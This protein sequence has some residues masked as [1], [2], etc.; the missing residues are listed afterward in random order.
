MS[1]ETAFSHRSRGQGVV[2]LLVVLGLAGIVAGGAAPGI[3]RISQEWELWGSAHMLE[4]SLQWARLHAISSNDSLALMI[5]ENG[6]RF[7]W[8]DAGGVRYDNSVRQ[9]PAGVRIVQSPRRPLRFYQHGNAVPAG[10][11]VVQGA[12]GTYRVVVN[13]GGRIRMQRD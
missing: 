5:D 11:F 9:L 6:R 8:V 4:T 10:T 2:E 12:A 7:Y 1:K 3:R 13:V